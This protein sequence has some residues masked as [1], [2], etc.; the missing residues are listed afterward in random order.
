[1]AKKMKKLEKEC[2]S[3]KTRFDG[4]NKSLV[5]MVT[6]VRNIFLL[7]HSLPIMRI[8]SFCKKMLEPAEEMFAIKKQKTSSRFL[9]CYTCFFNLF[10][11][12][13]KEK[14]FELITVKNQ[15]LENLCRAL[16]EERKGLYDKVQGAGSQPEVHTAAPTEE[17][18]VPEVKETAK[19]ADDD[20]PVQNPAT[21]APAAPAGTPTIETPLNKELAKLKAEQA[22]L[23]E[24]ASSFT[25]SHTIPSETDAGQEQGQCDGG[26]EPEQNHIEESNGEQ[27]QEGEQDG[28]QEQRDLEIESVD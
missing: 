23:K 8:R 6:D 24:I 1:M 7:C 13:I 22:R 9:M 4:C 5:D 20:H 2:Q 21:P 25:I 18:E 14:E 26:Q 19:D 28:H 10:Q 27:L 17:E 3:W 16:Q 11:R 12:T 15:K